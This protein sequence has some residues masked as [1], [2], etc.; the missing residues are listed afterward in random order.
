MTAAAAVHQHRSRRHRAAGAPHRRAGSRSRPRSSAKRPARTASR[1]TCARTAGTSRTH[2]LERLR[3]A[4][5]GAQRRAGDAATKS[6]RS[7]AGCAHTRRRWCPEQREE[8][9]TEGGLDLA[10]LERSAAGDDSA[11]RGGRVIGS[12][13][14]SIRT[15]RTLD[16]AK[17]L[18][19]PAVELHTGRYAH[20]WRAGRRSA[21]R[22]S[23]CR[24]ARRGTWGCSSTPA[25]GSPT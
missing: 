11:A 24:P 2:D 18:G 12:A 1:R 8:I 16:A 22:A 21:G 23:R 17:D 14:S 9:T 6:S 15:R 13:C 5:A 20:T 3:P 19:V 7:P 10:A 25:T 4:G